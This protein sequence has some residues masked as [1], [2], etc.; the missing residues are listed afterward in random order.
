VK[1]IDLKLGLMAALLA[2]ALTPQLVDAHARYDRSDPGAEGIVA[3]APAQVQV[4]FTEEL[5]SQGS[6]LEVVDSAGNRVDRG[7]SRVDLNDPDRKR[8]LISLGPLADGIYTVNWWTV[9]STDGDEAQGS[10]RFAVGASTVLPPLGDGSA[11]PS[12]TDHADDHAH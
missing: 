10:F 2:L 3:I 9:S 1:P 12:T 5:R 7:D 11:A 4:W 6:A 8:M